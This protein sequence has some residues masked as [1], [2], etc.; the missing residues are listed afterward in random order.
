[1]G[2]AYHKQ[3]IKLLYPDSIPHHLSDDWIHSNFAADMPKSIDIY[4]TGCGISDNNRVWIQDMF[5][6]IDGRVQNLDISNTDCK[7]F[8]TDFWYR[9]SFN[10]DEV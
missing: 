8:F 4:G 2:F 5:K 10:E 9:I 7:K 6:R 1:L 3:N